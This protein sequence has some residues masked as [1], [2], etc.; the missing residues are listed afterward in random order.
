MSLESAFLDQLPFLLAQQ[1]SG[2]YRAG[3]IVGVILVVLIVGA[4]LWKILK[5]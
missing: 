2:A 4:I 1:G 3:Q 5:R